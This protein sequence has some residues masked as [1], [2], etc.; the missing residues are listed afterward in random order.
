MANNLL[1]SQDQHKFVRSY[2][3]LYTALIGGSAFLLQ[4]CKKLTVL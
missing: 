4:F 2:N 3:E 1:G